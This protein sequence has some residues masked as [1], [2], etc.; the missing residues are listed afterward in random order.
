MKNN[1]IVKNCNSSQLPWENATAP[2]GA[3]AHSLGTTA[4]ENLLDFVLWATTCHPLGPMDPFIPNL[5]S[6]SVI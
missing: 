1:K 3:A 2:K 6:L 5:I 4:I